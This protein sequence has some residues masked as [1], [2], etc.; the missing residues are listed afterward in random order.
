MPQVTLPQAHPL[1]LID[2]RQRSGLTAE[3]AAAKARI[4]ITTLR[5]AERGSLA[6]MGGRLH[7]LARVYGVKAAALVCDPADDKRLTAELDRYRRECPPHRARITIQ[8]W[9]EDCA[10]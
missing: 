8:Q 6:I 9:R 2:Y 1:H 7:S 3:E 10:A 5:H 4:G